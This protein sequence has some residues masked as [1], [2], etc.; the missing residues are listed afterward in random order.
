MTKQQFFVKLAAL[1]QVANAADSD[2][3][4]REPWTVAA[5]A[6]NGFCQHIDAAIR[7]MVDCGVLTADEAANWLEAVDA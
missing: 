4:E 2:S 1:Y 7:A 3:T 5:M 6:G